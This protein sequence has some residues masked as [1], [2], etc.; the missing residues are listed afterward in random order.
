MIQSNEDQFG[1][2]DE[3][4]SVFPTG[5]YL[6]TAAHN[7]TRSGVLVDWAGICCKEP[8]LVCVSSL[9]G[10]A[11]DPLIRDSRSF[12]IGVLTGEDRMLERR[13][14]GM[15]PMVR[16]MASEPDDDPFDTLPTTMLETGSPIVKRCQ[17][18]LDCK[19]LRRIDLE[20]ETELFVGIVVGVQH[21]GVQI[22]IAQG[23]Q[24]DE[25]AQAED[26]F[27]LP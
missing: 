8:I 27:R 7:G 19:V 14:G 21:Q 26:R 11:I 13:F 6:L 18:W 23:Q 24:V 5:R 4:L 1:V 16:D 9:K 17:T 3:A 2:L 20:S 10:H 22:E 12:A 25:I 15:I